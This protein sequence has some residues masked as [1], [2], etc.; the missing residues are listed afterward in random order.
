MTEPRLGYS[1]NRKD[2]NVHS[3]HLFFVVVYVT[4]RAACSL[5]LTFTVLTLVI[6]WWTKEDLA[7]LTEFGRFAISGGN[8]QKSEVKNIDFFI[9]N[10]LRRQQE[11]LNRT[12]VECE[13]RMEKLNEQMEEARSQIVANRED[14]QLI[15][16][17]SLQYTKLLL[18][19]LTRDTLK[20][21]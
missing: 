11:S 2:N 7:K 5:A 17:L 16:S 12:K 10:E 6:H 15:A 19:N 1:S 4:F 9:V 20:F 8:L 13:K 18:E 3:H 14:D 21:R